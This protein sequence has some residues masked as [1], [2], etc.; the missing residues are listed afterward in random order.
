MSQLGM[1]NSTCHIIL[2]VTM[3]FKCLN[4]YNYVFSKRKLG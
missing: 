4:L 2:H 3:I 1:S